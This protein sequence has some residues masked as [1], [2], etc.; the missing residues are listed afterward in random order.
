MARLVNT[1]G[2]TVF[3]G[4]IEGGAVTAR[5]Q[6]A[7]AAANVADDALKTATWTKTAGTALLNLTAPT[8]PT[9]IT[10]GTYAVSLYVGPTATLTALGSYRATLTLDVDGAAAEVVATAYQSA[11]VDAPDPALCLALTYYLPA[12]AVVRFVILNADGAAT[13]SFDGTVSIQQ[14]A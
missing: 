1:S 4:A 14:L 12:A 5:A 2:T 10:A 6:Y 11:D 3:E 9:V 7:A 8:L 13:R